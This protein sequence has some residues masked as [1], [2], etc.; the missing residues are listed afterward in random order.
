[1]EVDIVFAGRPSLEMGLAEMAGGGEAPSGSEQTDDQNTHRARET[2]YG[3][4][5]PKQTFMHVGGIC[6]QKKKKKLPVCLLLCLCC[7][8]KDYHLTIYVLVCV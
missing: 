3:D 1:M 5:I 4:R 7:F 2:H 6:F 8:L